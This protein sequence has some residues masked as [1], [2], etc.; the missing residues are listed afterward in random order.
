[1]KGENIVCFAPTD[2][3][4]MNPSCTTHIMQNLSKNNKVLYINPFSSDLF[5]TAETKI[6]QRLVRKIK[7][8]AKFLRQPKKNLYVFSPLFIPLHGNRLIDAINNLFLMLQIKSICLFLLMSKPI[9]WMEN[10]RAASM[11]EWFDSKIVVYHVS[12]LFE[13]CDYTSNRSILLKREEQIR[14]KCDVMICVSNKL[15]E[16]KASGSDNV[17]YLPHGVDFELFREAAKNRDYF[18]NELVNIPRPIAGYYGTLTSHNDYEL[19]QYCATNL[20][21]IS[22]VLAGQVTGGDHTELSKKKNV[23]FIGRIPYERIPHLCACFDV[24]L[25]QWKV[26]KWIRFC[27]PLKFLE[28][29]AS[30]NPIVSVYIDEIADQYSDL[31]SIAESKEDYCK[32]IVWELNQDNPDRAAQRIKAAKEHSW[33]RQV[34]RLSRI[35]QDSINTKCVEN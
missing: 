13:E 7:S 35:I 31:V 22:F 17:F 10:L 33:E 1:M 29:M 30:G 34:K 6:T 24:C 26:D 21:Y 3:W 27:N 8:V 15:R 28:Y 16:L 19:L 11:L 20:P 4:G 32:A 14:R 12:D 25:L 5:S 18:I 9:L 23:Y 2:W